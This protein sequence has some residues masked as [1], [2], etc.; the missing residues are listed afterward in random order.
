M[1]KL[2]KLH[3]IGAWLILSF[4]LI[5][6]SQ[7]VQAY[8]YDDFT[9]S[10]IVASLWVDVGPNTG[11]LSQPGDG[12]LY[13]ND[14][15]G[16]QADILR[17]YSRINGAF[18][19]SIQ[20][21]DFQAINDTQAGLGMG[22]TVALRLEDGSNY[23]YLSEYK[24]N[25]GLGHRAFSVIG[26]TRTFLN[27]VA[28]TNVNSGWLGMY[29]NG[30]LGAGGEVDFWYDSGAGWT[31]LDSCA[32]NFSEAPYFSVAGSDLFGSSL[33]FRVAQVQVTPI[34][35]GA[36]LMGSGLLGLAGLRRFRKL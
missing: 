29:Y 4:A 10:G 17:S 22:S 36:L 19:V 1:K 25:G 2:V 9:S 18:F 7:P 6:F 5:L 28:L 16:S 35:T 30:I 13:F 21:S 20:Y 26:G 33:S 32:P 11:L 27:Y 34:P 23:S 24:N 12:Y 3:F 31:L 15:S 8:V 14:S